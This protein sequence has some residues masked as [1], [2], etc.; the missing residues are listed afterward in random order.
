MPKPYDDS[1]KILISENPQDFASWLLKGA[2][3]KGK[4]STEFTGRKVEADALLDVIMEDE[5]ILLHIE[6]QSEND[7][8]MPERM[9][10]YAF[11]ARLEHKQTVYSCVIYL[12]NV[13]EAP[14]SPLLWKLPNGQE[15][16]RFY[17]QSIE[18]AKLSPEELRQ[19]GLV[20]LLPLMILTKGGATHEVAEEI[21]KGLQVASKKESLP[22][23]FV[24]ASLAFKSE[25]DREWLRK[26][27]RE[28]HD[29]LR[30]TPI[31]QEILREG[32][33]EER[34]QRLQ[35]QRQ[36]IVKLVQMR[37]PEIL[38]LAK[39]QADIIKDPEVLQNLIAKMFAV[40][41]LQEAVQ[42]LLDLPETDKEN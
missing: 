24:L 34:Q 25:A 8:S 32:R 5:E 6:F 15:I 21:M 36:T 3:V 11:R 20:G 16:L 42:Y 23:A 12:R 35:D 40:S 41:T 31:Y 28:M 27:F 19:T 37:F 14:Q 39:K 18:L 4:R 33:E 7:P 30:E 1:L 29:I 38:S 13:G 17:F 9:L 22:A 10:E 26:R 2:Q